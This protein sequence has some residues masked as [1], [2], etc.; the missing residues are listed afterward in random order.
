MCDA[1][2]GKRR[3][4]VVLANRLAY[5]IS[6]SGVAVAVSPTLTSITVLL[7]VR[8]KQQVMNAV[9]LHSDKRLWGVLGC[10]LL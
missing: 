3:L 9:A 2:P 10:G 1:S 8:L 5:F 6:T 7:I 4:H